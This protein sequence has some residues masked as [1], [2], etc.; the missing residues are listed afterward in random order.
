M[1]IEE[2]LSAFYAARNEDERLASQSGAVE[3]RVTT[4]Y[5][6]RYLRPGDRIMEIGCGTGRY[7]LHYARLGH[8]VTALDLVEGNLSVLRSNMRPGDDIDVTQ[9]NALDLSRWPNEAFDVTLLLGPMY[10][11]Y[12]EA[13]KRTALSEALR[14][15]RRGGLLFVAYCQFDASMIQAVFSGRK[16]YDFVVENGLLDE[17]T[18][19]PISNPA[20]IFELYR[21]EDVD[22][23]DALLDAERLHYVGTDM[24]TYYR[25]DEI[26]ALDARLYE[27]Y[28]AYT[29]S[30]CENPHLVGASNH[31]LDVLR[32]K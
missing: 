28:I 19:L 24:F 2:T 26:D 20:G 3:F 1:S 9:G 12:T 22:G 7:S 25:R 21:R 11:L 30:I 27:K 10:H 16:L 14:V 5:I 31:T 8:S 32:K 4:A 6:D 13:D 17:R 23:L 15:T 18:W 29:M